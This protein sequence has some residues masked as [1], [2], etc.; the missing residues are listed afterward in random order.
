M[1]IMNG[2]DLIET[3][4]TLTGLPRSVLEDNIPKTLLDQ[5]DYLL[6]VIPNIN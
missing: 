2:L 3:M 5:R 6:T 4:L 1:E